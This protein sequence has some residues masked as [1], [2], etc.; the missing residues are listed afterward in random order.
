MKGKMVKPRGRK[1]REAEPEEDRMI[2]I[3][4]SS[5]D[6]NSVRDM[7]AYFNVSLNQLLTNLIKSN[8]YYFRNKERKENEPTPG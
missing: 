8:C 5:D 6:Y 1:P 2:V 3:R 7:A 4:I